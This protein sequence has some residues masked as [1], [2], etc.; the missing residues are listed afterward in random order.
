[1]RTR[2]F[3]GYGELKLLGWDRVGLADLSDRFNQRLARKRG[4]AGQEGVEGS[5]QAV[6]VGA[7]VEDLDGDVLAVA[8]VASFSSPFAPRKVSL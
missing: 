1:M 6:D 5:T 4:F 8:P 2:L 3:V 7:S